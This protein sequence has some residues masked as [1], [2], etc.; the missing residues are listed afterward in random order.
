MQS[1]AREFAPHISGTTSAGSKFHIIESMPLPRPL[2]WSVRHLRFWRR[3]RNM[4]LEYFKDHRRFFIRRKTIFFCLSLVL[5]L[6]SL[7]FGSVSII[8]LALTVA[9]ALI[10]SGI[11][12]VSWRYRSILLFLPAIIIVILGER[13]VRHLSFPDSPYNNLDVWLFVQY[14]SVI[15]VVFFT[16]LL[17]CDSKIRR[18]LR[19]I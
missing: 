1:R 16:I 11:T 14:I 7:W 6:M 12:I 2:N 4:E 3:L 5:L 15:F 8:Y 9:I 19:F 13:F 10:Y 17:L 18:Y